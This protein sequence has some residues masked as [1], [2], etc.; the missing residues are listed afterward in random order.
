M[1]QTILI[2]DE[3]YDKKYMCKATIVCMLTSYIIEKALNLKSTNMVTPNCRIPRYKKELE[4]E[5]YK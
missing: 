4:L 1:S 3:S 2:P 5:S